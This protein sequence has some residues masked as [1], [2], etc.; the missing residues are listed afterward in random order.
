MGRAL[1]GRGWLGYAVALVAALATLGGR[2]AAG[3][4]TTDDPA[5]LLFVTPILLAAYVG[6][7]GPGL[8]ATVLVT[9]ATNVFLLAPRGDFSIAAGLETAEWIVLAALGALISVLADALHRSRERV[10]RGRRV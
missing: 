3:F 10:A 4:D 9:F 5:L 7:L 8:L 6:G 2:L 1:R